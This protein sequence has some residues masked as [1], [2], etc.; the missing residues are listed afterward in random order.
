MYAAARNRT[1]PQPDV[2]SA[3]PEEG[4]FSLPAR[5]NFPTERINQ[6]KDD[7]KK[8]INKLN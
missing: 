2:S 7:Q 5:P 6:K 8:T 1:F 4:P 3:R